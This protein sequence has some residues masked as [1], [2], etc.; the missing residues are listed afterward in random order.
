MEGLP[1]ALVAAVTAN[2]TQDALQALGGW[3]QEAVTHLTTWAQ[4]RLMQAV[5]S[6]SH[7]LQGVYE[8]QPHEHR[9]SAWVPLDVSMGALA[10]RDAALSSD[11]ARWLRSLSP[12]AELY[13][14]KHELL[15]QPAHAQAMLLSGGRRVLQ[16]DGRW[17]A[18]PAG[19][20]V[21]LAQ[22]V[23]PDATFRVALAPRPPLPGDPSEDPSLLVTMG[24][25]TLLIHANGTVLEGCRVLDLPASRAGGAVLVRRSAGAVEVSGPRGAVLRC[26]TESRV[27]SLTLAYWDHA[28][29]VG[30]FGT[31]N[32]EPADEWT[33]PQGEPA[34]SPD[35]LAL[36]W[37]V[38]GR[39]EPME[40]R[41]RC[42]SRLCQE[43]FLDS[44]SSLGSCFRV[45]DPAPFLS[46]CEED[47]CREPGSRAACSLAAAYVT[48]C[49]HQHVPLVTP[50]ACVTPASDARLRRALPGQEEAAA[51][52]P[53]EGDRAATVVLVPDEWPCQQLGG[54][55]C[56]VRAA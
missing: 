38:G 30:L 29:S 34:P 21:L 33:T 47:A 35:A 37:Q 19:C 15:G 13:R 54:S 23:R 18:L 12:S 32:L 49:N 25:V 10:L 36:S 53:C 44:T 8:L 26:D 40:E 3:G 39:C 51:A 9:L 48:R 52:T 50:A 6:I 11:T 20:A 42:P 43:L 5:R 2:E 31:N 45:V 28:R 24:P 14:L 16:F 17:L 55:P 56:G 27:C 4:R 46:A 22:D 41:P 1:T 7:P